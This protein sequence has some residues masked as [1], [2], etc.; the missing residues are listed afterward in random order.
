M[1][2]RGILLTLL[3]LL[4]VVVFNSLLTMTTIPLLGSPSYIPS[5]LPFSTESVEHPPCPTWVFLNPGTSSF[6]RTRCILSH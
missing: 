4:I 6:Y 1:A 3:L 2:A 5:S